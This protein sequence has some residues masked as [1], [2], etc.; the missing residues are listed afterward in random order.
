MGHKWEAHH[1]EMRELGAG[2]G[3]KCCENPC[4]GAT[5]LPVPSR[6]RFQPGS[7]LPFQQ[8]LRQGPGLYALA[9]ACSEDKNTQ[10]LATPFPGEGCIVAA[11]T[12]EEEG[13]GNVQSSRELSASAG[14]RIVV[15][16]VPVSKDGAR[17]GA[18]LSTNG[19]P[20]PALLRPADFY[21]L[22]ATL[23]P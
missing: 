17:K 14:Q 3:G 5:D 21:R 22:P 2:T 19:F 7:K 15:E 23:F 10:F 20:I 8:A 6:S 4:T 13:L 16:W 12:L 11:V 9:V 1:S 18:A